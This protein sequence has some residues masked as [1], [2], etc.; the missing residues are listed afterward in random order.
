MNE[1]WMDEMQLV[2]EYEYEYEYEY[3]V[4]MI[5]RINIIVARETWLH[6]S[7]HC[8][9]SES[10]SESIGTPIGLQAYDALP[11]PSF[12]SVPFHW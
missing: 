9:R 3:S 4:I 1:Q 5:H 7:L 2:Y 11:C 10:V 12:H 6:Q 8:R